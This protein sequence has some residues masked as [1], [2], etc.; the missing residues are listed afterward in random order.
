MSVGGDKPV[1][2][3]LQTEARGAHLKQRDDWPA[4]IAGQHHET[5]GERGG[6]GASKSWRTFRGT[7]QNPSNCLASRPESL[8]KSERRKT[9]RLTELKRDTQVTPQ[10]GGGTSCSFKIGGGWRGVLSS[11]TTLWNQPL[12]VRLI[13]VREVAAASS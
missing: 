6:G 3:S 7:L 13:E 1:T 10:T 8:C 4:A 5:G 9:R 12:S 11:N 2:I